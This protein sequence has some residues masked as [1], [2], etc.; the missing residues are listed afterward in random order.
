MFRLLNDQ[1][2]NNFEHKKNVLDHRPKGIDQR[3]F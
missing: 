1:S 3:A 2:N